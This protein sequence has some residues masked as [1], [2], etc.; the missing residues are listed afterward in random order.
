[1]GLLKMLFGAKKSSSTVQTPPD[2]IYLTLP[3]KLAAVERA[4]GE[5]VAARSVSIVLIAHFPGTLEELRSV[6]ARC[7][8][9]TMA[10]LASELSPSL[11]FAED[12]TVDF[13]VAERH[14]LIAGD[15]R[16]IAFAEALTCRAR[17]IHLL[18]LDGG[19]LRTFGG[20]GLQDMMKKLG[21]KDDEPIESKLVRRRIANAQKK[22]EQRIEAMKEA[23]GKP[24]ADT[25][26][27]LEAK[28]RDT[29]FDPF[30]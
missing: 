7:E 20:P 17:V 4:I 21:M 29:G 19:L 26:Q 18:S 16:V 3:A 24:G 2:L 1:M 10:I 25:L 28:I 22:M 23:D 12:A 6:A 11:A 13:I 15:E 14:A 30:E 5:R 8:H 27:W 9:E